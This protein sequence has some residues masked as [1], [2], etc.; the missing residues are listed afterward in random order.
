MLGWQVAL[1]A[2]A[3]F[4]EDEMPAK[5]VELRN[6]LGEP[7]G[8]LPIDELPDPQE[9]TT[10]ERA[11]LPVNK[12]PT[13]LVTAQRKRT[14]GQV[15][16]SSTGGPTFR[17]TYR[18]RLYIWARAQGYAQ[19]NRIRNRLSLAVT[20]LLSATTTLDRADMAVDPLTLEERPA[21]TVQDRSRRSIAAT[22]LEFEVTIEETVVVEGLGVVDTGIIETLPPHPALD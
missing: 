6:R 11:A 2:V 9:Y 17:N 22:W 10:E 5:L 8:P 3:G 1:D 21:E 16:I 18:L 19:V 14:G 4:L 20:E 13:I 7:E 12:W 15:D